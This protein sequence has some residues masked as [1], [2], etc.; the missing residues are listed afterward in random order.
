MLAEGA[1]GHWLA[2]FAQP[3][4]ERGELRASG[5]VLLNYPQTSPAFQQVPLLVAG[6][7][8]P[9]LIVQE[10]PAFWNRHYPLAGEVELQLLPPGDAIRGDDRVVRQVRGWLERRFG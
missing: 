1:G 6:L 3:G 7:R 10:N 4:S 9:T 5:L 8:L 2:D